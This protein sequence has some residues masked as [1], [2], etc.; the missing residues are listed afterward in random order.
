MTYIRIIYSLIIDDYSYCTRFRLPNKSRLLKLAVIGAAVAP[1][2]PNHAIPPLST[3]RT[4][5]HRL[6]AP[7]IYGLKKALL[8]NIADSMHDVVIEL[9]G[10]SNKKSAIKK[11]PDPPRH[12]V[13]TIAKLF[14]QH[15]VG[16]IAL[17][18]RTPRRILAAKI[19]QLP[20][21]IVASVLAKHAT[22]NELAPYAAFAAALALASPQT[23]L[24][25]AIEGAIG[26]YAGNKLYQALTK[27]PS[28]TKE[29]LAPHGHIP[30]SFVSKEINLKKNPATNGRTV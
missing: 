9:L 18:A 1:P 22:K 23:S 10:Q 16:S 4:I 20:A 19:A 26:I 5:A 30:P 2:T 29:D 6:P 21:P 3:I 11:Q 8:M 17:A 25:Q 15:S 14:V 7:T 28:I 13:N 27:I 24:S 12:I